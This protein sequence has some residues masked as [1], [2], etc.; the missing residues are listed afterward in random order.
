MTIQKQNNIFKYI[1]I[2]FYPLIYIISQLIYVILSIRHFLYDKNILSSYHFKNIVTICIGNLNLGGSGKTPLTNFLINLL[3]NQFKVAVLSRGYGRKTKGFKVVQ[4]NDDYLQVGDEPLMYKLKH[5][6]IIVAVCEDRV[7]GVRELL[8]I[9]PDIQIILL[10][11][12]FQHRRIKAD[13]NILVSDYSKPFFKD[14]I[15]PLGKLR[16]LKSRVK[17]ADILVISKTPENIEESAIQSFMHQIQSYFQKDIYFSKIEYEHFYSLNSH[18]KINPIK[19]L[20]QYNCILVTG[21]ANP[22]P[23]AIFIKEYAQHFYH[24]KYP[25]HHAFTQKDFELMKSIYLEW[26]K[27]YPPVIIITTEK[28]AMR[29]KTFADAHFNLPIFIAPI[30]IQFFNSSSFENK[31]LN[32]VRTNS[33]NSPL[34]S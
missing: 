9:Y 16:D 17:N 28:D 3:K 19:E 24:L 7:Q 27:K 14:K 18:Q 10:D 26:Q 12:A 31:I 21:I 5:P 20:S 32:Y 22:L 29:L 13:V 6:E 2:L 23:L 33:T 34:H 1:Y 11:D 25:D 8:R 30:Q 4:I 15:F